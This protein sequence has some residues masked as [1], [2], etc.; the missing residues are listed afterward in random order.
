MTASLNLRSGECC[1]YRG[2]YF[3]ELDEIR[4]RPSDKALFSELVILLEDEGEHPCSALLSFVE[5]LVN[6]WTA[7]WLLLLPLSSSVCQTC[8]QI[9]DL[10]AEQ[11]QCIASP[12][13]RGAFDGVLGKFSQKGYDLSAVVVFLVNDVLLEVL[14][15]VLL[16]RMEAGEKPINILNP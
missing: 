6:A 15:T 4:H 16:P 1:I 14:S 7:A 2:Y 5:Q 12:L 13:P 9:D 8:G 3:E 11:G 10:E